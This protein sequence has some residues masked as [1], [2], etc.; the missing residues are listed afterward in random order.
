MFPNS[1]SRVYFFA[2]EVGDNRL[3]TEEIPLFCTER[4]MVI[5]NG[6]KKRSYIAS[7]RALPFVR[8][9]YRGRSCFWNIRHRA[10]CNGSLG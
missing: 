4:H 2:S 10:E 9:F 1:W 5:N 3:S 8:T 6:I 7:E